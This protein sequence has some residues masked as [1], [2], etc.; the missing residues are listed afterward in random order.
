ML[1][2]IPEKK[3]SLVLNAQQQQNIPQTPTS[4]RCSMRLSRPPE[5]FSPFLYYVL[6]TD[7][8]EPEGYEEAMQAYAK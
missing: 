1:D 2:E 6:L 3:M 7:S 5:I 4:V 8:G